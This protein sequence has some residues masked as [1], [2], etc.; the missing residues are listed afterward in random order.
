[1]RRDGVTLQDDGGVGNDYAHLV[2]ADPAVA[3]KSDMVEESEFSGKRRGRG[4]PPREERQQRS[5]ESRNDSIAVPLRTGTG[6]S[7]LIVP[8]T[9]VRRPAG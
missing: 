5:I 6:F 9:E 4:Q 3:K 1:M 8:A 7:P 2:T